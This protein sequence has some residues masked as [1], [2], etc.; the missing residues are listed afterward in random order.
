MTLIERKQNF[1]RTVVMHSGYGYSKTS[2]SDLYIAYM[3]FKNQN[4]ISNKA[5]IL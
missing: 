2:N 1:L 5:Y 4:P 3:V